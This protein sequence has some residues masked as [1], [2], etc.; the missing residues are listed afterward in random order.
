MV[1][2]RKTSLKKKFKGT[3]EN[4]VNYF[5]LVAEEVREIMAEL[6][7]KKFQDL[8]GKSEYLEKNKA[9]KHWKA[10]KY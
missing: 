1:L 8:I 10:K 9:I 7:V 4:V 6:G 3:P 2:L 5:F